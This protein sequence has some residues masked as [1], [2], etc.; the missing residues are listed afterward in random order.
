MKIF[1]LNLW[2]STI[3]LIGLVLF[4]SLSAAQHGMEE[5]GAPLDD[6]PSASGEG[7]G[8]VPATSDPGDDPDVNIPGGILII[9]RPVDIG[10]A[11]KSVRGHGMMSVR[12]EVP[13]LDDQ[14]AFLFEGD[15][16]FELDRSALS[17]VRFFFMTGDL[18]ESWTAEASLGRWHSEAFQLEPNGLVNVPLKSLG[19]GARRLTLDA[20]NTQRSLHVKALVRSETTT[21][22][23]VRTR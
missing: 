17:S 5:P 21:V 1:Q 15:L 13:L 22:L 18:Q 3:V 12:T 6:G 23:K 7:V 9:G 20:A 14:V 11:I 2:R 8:T 4:G 16:S 10:A 19:E